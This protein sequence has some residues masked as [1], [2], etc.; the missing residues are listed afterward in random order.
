MTK[1]ERRRI[2][3]LIIITIIVIVIKVNKGKKVEDYSGEGQSA[4]PTE[5][6]QEENEIK[7]TVS[8]KLEETKYFGDFEMTGIQITENNG[9]ATLIASVKNT[10]NR[11]I[12]EFP[13]TVNVLDEDGEK[14]GVFKA[15]LGTTEPGEIRGINASTNMDISQIYD[16]EIEF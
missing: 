2:A 11:K 10:S 16:I 4:L 5:Y 8:E 7:Q 15:Y 12:E 6:V 9:L 1:L 13:F 14:I 3:F